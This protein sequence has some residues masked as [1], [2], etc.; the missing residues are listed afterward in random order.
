[1]RF[2]PALL[3]SLLA[4]PLLASGP[5]TSSAGP[6]EPASGSSRAAFVAADASM[7]AALELRDLSRFES[8]GRSADAS[9]APAASRAPVVTPGTASMLIELDPETHEWRLRAVS[10]PL[11]IAPADDP[12][13]E[14]SFEGLVEEPLPG[15]GVMVDLHGRFMDHAVV[16]LDADGRPVYGCVPTRQAAERWMRATAASGKP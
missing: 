6:G 9:V 1:M 3:A 12:S 11:E 8:T 2:H 7:R 14:R 5:G 16:R 15:G 13:L 10:G 4:A